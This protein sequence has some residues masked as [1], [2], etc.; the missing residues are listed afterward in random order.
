MGLF[1]SPTI[2]A[3]RLV[4]IERKLDA[5][6]DHFGIELPARE[7]DDVRDLAISGRKIDAIKRYREKTGVGLAEAK[8]YV[9]SLT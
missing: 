6:M 3:R 5:I 7:H 4:E 2:S 9:D 8:E 1:S